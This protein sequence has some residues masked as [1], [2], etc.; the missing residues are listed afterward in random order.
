M[1]VACLA[2]APASAQEQEMKEL[3]GDLGARIQAAGRTRV[4]VLDFV[5]LDNKPTKLG[6]F[7]AQQLAVAFAEGGGT[8]EVVDQSQ[9]PQLFDQIA[10]L[11]EGLI[12]QTTKQ[13][14]GKVT[15]TEVVVV[16]T[17]IPSSITV[18]ID[19]KAIDLRTAKV[20]TAKSTKVARLGGIVERLA[21]ESEGG[22]TGSPPAQPSN[23]AKAEAAEKARASVTTRSDLGLLFELDDCAFESGTLACTLTV[24]NETRNRWIEVG[25]RSRVWDESGAEYPAGMVAIANST[26][27]RGCLQ[28]EILKGVPT[29]LSLSFPNYSEE[30]AVVQQLRIFWGTIRGIAVRAEPSTSSGFHSANWLTLLPVAFVVARPASPRRPRRGA[31]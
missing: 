24:T 29:R 10:K 20:L 9:L 25:L 13:E 17:V 16:A 21:T 28:K 12:D 31:C 15:S 4:T 5:D 19:V 23:A 1:I 30:S 27:E 7:L 6:K 26:S 14:L 22:S 2:G 11:S 3:A 18:R 8:L